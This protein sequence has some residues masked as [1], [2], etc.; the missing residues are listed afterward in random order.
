MKVICISGKAQHGKDTTAEYMLEE[1]ASSGKS[2][3]VTHYGGLLKYI[4][5]TFFGWDGNKNKAGRELLQTVGTDVIRKQNPDY[6]VEFIADFL[7]MF[8][9]LWDY[10]I[11]PDCRF[12]NEL[13]VL[14]EHG[15]DVT[16]V[17]VVRFNFE[18]PL[19]LEQK[20]HPSETALDGSI[21]DVY[22]YNQ[23]TL[24][25]LQYEIRHKMGFIF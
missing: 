1:L 11:I 14:R 23:G 15:L 25:D 13:D 2:V 20:N 10:V 18:S 24:K 4:C 16:H 9:N 19:T 12:P 21:P 8:P 17:R 3:L 6:W 7:K 5:K 22:I